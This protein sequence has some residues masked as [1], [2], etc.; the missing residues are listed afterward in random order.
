MLRVLGKWLNAIS[1][2]CREAVRRQSAALDRELPLR[3]RLGL[4]IHLLLCK[5]CRRYETQIELMRKAARDPNRDELLLPRQ[6]LP[7]ETKKRIK[8]RLRSTKEHGFQ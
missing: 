1:P 3:E 6:T 4:R 2:S 5:W 7:P 8:Q